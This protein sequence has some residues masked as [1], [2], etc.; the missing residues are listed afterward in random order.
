LKK[1]RVI[2]IGKSDSWENAPK[3]GNFDV[4]G[5]NDLVTHRDVD[6]IFDMHQIEKRW[7]ATIENDFMNKLVA[8]QGDAKATEILHIKMALLKTV[9]RAE[10][11][12]I[13]LVS[14]QE[15]PDISKNIVAYPYKEI[16]DTFRTDY[17]SNT[18]DYMLAYAIWEGYTHIDLYGINMAIG[19]EMEWEKPGCDF[20]TGMALGRGIRVNI[21][22]HVS[23]LMKPGRGVIYGYETKP[24]FAEES[25]VDVQALKFSVMERVVL[26]NIIPPQKGDYE[27]VKS[28]KKLREELVFTTEEREK[29]NLRQGERGMVLWDDGTEF[30]KEIEVNDFSLGA[31][32]ESLKW[33]SDKGNF[34]EDHIPIYE[35]FVHDIG[36]RLKYNI[37]ISEKDIRAF[38]KKERKFLK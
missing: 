22:S 17:F 8:V 25:N 27:K 35:R 24:S 32:I 18:I 36:G 37:I 9:R 34:G 30:E 4:W 33:A 6:M 21:K 10:E 3:C 23:T 20:W 12:G 29:L 26:T 15:H 5:V 7:D 16:V 31:I 28:V 19:S 2:L 14:L 11:L 38:D 13:Q 1:K